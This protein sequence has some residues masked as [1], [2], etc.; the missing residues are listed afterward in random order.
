MSFISRTA[1]SWK[2]RNSHRT[3]AF[4]DGNA[5]CDNREVSIGSGAGA[6]N[7]T[8]ATWPARGRSSG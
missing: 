4:G 5:A 8:E 3:G 6:V 7:P 1:S 2:P